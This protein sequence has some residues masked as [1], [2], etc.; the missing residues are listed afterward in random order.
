MPQFP[1]RPFG[2]KKHASG[3]PDYWIA[4]QT[5]E[6][7]IRR[8]KAT[9]NI[10]TAQ[11]LLAVMVGMYAVYHGPQGL[12]AIALR[13]RRQTLRLAGALRAAGYELRAE[14]VF[15]TLKVSPGDRGQAGIVEAARTRGINLRVYAD[16]DCGVTLDETVSNTD[17]DD[18]VQPF[19]ADRPALPLPVDETIPAPHRR[20]GPI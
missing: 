13:V 19:S 2:V 7:H 4:L 6:H 8:D 18:L 1:G 11:V 5:S 17:L 15:D 12:R 10:C 9:S 16:G 20:H 3:R 14:T